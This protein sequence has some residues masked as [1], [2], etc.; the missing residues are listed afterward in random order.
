VLFLLT[1]A[2]TSRWVADA[3]RYALMGLRWAARSV[4]LAW[5]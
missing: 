4:S 1:A 5:S 2:V 3:F